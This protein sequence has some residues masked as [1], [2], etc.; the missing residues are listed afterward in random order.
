M[1]VSILHLLLLATPATQAPATT[2]HVSPDG[3]DNNNGTTEQDAWLTLAHAASS[4]RNG[5]IVLIHGGTYTAGWAARSNTTWMNYNGELV[6][7][8]VPTATGS[9]GGATLRLTDSN[10]VK[11][12]GIYFDHCLRAINDTNSVNIE[13][14]ECVFDSNGIGSASPTQARFLYVDSLY[15]SRDTFMGKQDAHSDS[16]NNDIV[17]IDRCRYY[18]VDSCDISG[19]SHYGLMLYDSAAISKWPVIRNSYFHDGHGLI[20]LHSTINHVLVERCLFDRQYTGKTSAGTHVHIH[21]DSSIIRYNVLHHNKQGTYPDYDSYSP[22]IDLYTEYEDATSKY[23]RIYNNTVKGEGQGLATKKYLFGREEGA[24]L[25]AGHEPWIDYNVWKN[26]VFW[27]GY[28]YNGRL[29]A[30]IRRYNNSYTQ[31][32]QFTDSVSTCFLRYGNI[33]DSWFHWGVGVDEGVNNETLTLSQAINKNGCVENNNTET[34][35]K[36][37]ANLTLQD[38]SPALQAAAPETWVASTVNPA[39]T[40]IP[41]KDAGYFFPGWNARVPGDS[42]KIGNQLVRISAIS[43]NTLTVNRAITASAGDPVYYYAADKWLG[44]APDIGALGCVPFAYD[45]CLMGATVTSGSVG[46]MTVNRADVNCYFVAIGINSA[47][48]QVDSCWIP[49]GQGVPSVVGTRVLR[50]T[51]TSGIAVEIWQ[52]VNPTRG[53]VPVRVKTSSNVD[54]AWGLITMKG[55]HLST[56]MGTPVTTQSGSSNSVNLDVSGGGIILWATMQSAVTPGTG[57]TTIGSKSDLPGSKVLTILKSS[58][59]N[60]TY[61][62]LPKAPLAAG[63]AAALLVANPYQGE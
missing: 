53:P 11:I 26:N 36:L 2:Y 44:S 38:I 60:I 22:V 41:V 37:N 42:V 1:R 25:P 33:G 51:Q 50:Q 17:Q 62:Q 58:T 39:S 15:L 59:G 32:S 20:N 12:K 18:L 49:T 4:I 21:S 43:S 46:T 55:I 16:A 14:R 23:N 61:T 7:L 5:D 48:V 24:G 45:T 31:F 3:D 29:A 9:V 35:V 8:N 57:V 30:Y 13:I 63:G 10:N 52:I 40:S 19:G 54:F 56:P 6:K 27:G 47:S 28:G 34:D